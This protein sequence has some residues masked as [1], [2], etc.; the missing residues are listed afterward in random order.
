MIDVLGER[1]NHQ[2]QGLG[3]AILERCVENRARSGAEL[4]ESLRS[5]VHVALVETCWAG[6][7]C[8]AAVTAGGE[9][10]REQGRRKQR[11][12]ES[13]AWPAQNTHPPGGGGSRILWR[14]G[15]PQG[16]GE[17]DAA[18]NDAAHRAAEPADEARTN[19]LGGLGGK[20]GDVERGWHCG[21]I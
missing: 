15:P 1:G 10:T 17:G 6:G 3:I 2:L 7:G 11:G 5:E 18:D 19:P 21:Q 8:G 4:G 9:Q 14:C 13:D 20:A 16:T 12:R